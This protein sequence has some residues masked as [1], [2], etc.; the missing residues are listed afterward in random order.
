[1]MVVLAIMGMLAT[2][3]KPT[4]DG[5]QARARRVEGTTHLGSFHKYL[6]LYYLDHKS[7]T[8]DIGKLGLSNLKSTYYDVG[9]SWMGLPRD[10]SF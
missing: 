3:A 1:M 6:K 2:T 8:Y 9:F 4:F 5:M 10:K 7:Y